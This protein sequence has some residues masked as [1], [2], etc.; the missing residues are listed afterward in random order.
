MTTAISVLFLSICM[1]A[2]FLNF[3]W[4]APCFRHQKPE[5]FPEDWDSDM[6][7]YFAKKRKYDEQL[8]AGWRYVRCGVFWM[9]LAIA[10]VAFIL[11]APYK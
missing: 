3:W 8:T 5:Q 1:V 7:P 9:L 6:S 11:F 10:C 4:S 2:S